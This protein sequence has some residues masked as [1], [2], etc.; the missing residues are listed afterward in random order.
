M[1]GLSGLSHTSGDDADASTRR[2]AY[3]LPD[4][5]A[6]YLI[7]IGDAHSDALA[8]TGKGVVQWRPELCLGQ[9]RLENCVPDL[10]LP[11]M[12]V[13]E[14]ARKGAGS[15]LLGVAPD[16]GE[17]KEDWLPTLYEAI[18]CGLDIISGFHTKLNEIPDLAN[19][20]KAKGVR[21]VD[22]R[23]PPKRVPVASGRKRAGMRLLT[24]GT[25][26]AVG[27]KYTALAIQQEMRRR[28]IP[29]T[30]RATG[31]TGIIISGNGVPMDCVV[32][33][34]L[35]G[36]AELVS[37]DNDADHWDI[38][39]GQGS[40]F[41][42]AYAA[43][44]VGLMHGSQPD[45]VVL[46]HDIA[47]PHIDDYEDYPLPDISDCIERNLQVGSLTNPAIKCIGVS[48]NTSSVED[49]ERPRLLA[50]YGAATGLPCVDPVAGDVGPI[51]DALAAAF[52]QGENS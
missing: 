14:A 26:C 16:G 49:A 5:A 34:F 48:L 46:C 38:I 1:T 17:I 36:A 12:S 30:F 13:R 31:Q 19:A 52:P 35:S 7:F 22:V 11:E 23:T 6:P 44:S 45:A 20:A 43:V 3:S 15:L 39:E 33:D 47:R 4:L 40:L 37:P 27:K 42:P 8:K 9:L 2:A 10:G 41:H 18:D 51:V 28:N 21:L 50:A 29:A 25:D 32:S 24:I